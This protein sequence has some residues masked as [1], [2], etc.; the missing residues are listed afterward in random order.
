MWLSVLNSV[1]TAAL[2]DTVKNVGFRERQGILEEHEESN[3]RKG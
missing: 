1:G 2:L 3:P